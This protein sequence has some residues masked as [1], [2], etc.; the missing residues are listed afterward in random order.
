M[1]PPGDGAA[2]F[3]SATRRGGA[4]NKTWQSRP[5]QQCDRRRRILY[6]CLY[7][8]EAPVVNQLVNL[9][10]LVDLSQCCVDPMIEHIILD[11]SHEFISVS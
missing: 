6:E 5:N 9:F 7:T 2:A 11:F 8:I 10:L 1:G 3:R 4:E